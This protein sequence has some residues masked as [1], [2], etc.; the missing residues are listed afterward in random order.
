MKV[1]WE[2][3]MVL[4]V[5]RNDECPCG[6]MQKFKYCC[7][8]KTGRPMMFGRPKGLKKPLTLFQRI[9]VAQR[10][11]TKGKLPPAPE[12]IQKYKMGKKPDGGSMDREIAKIVEEIDNG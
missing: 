7:I 1:V 12:V 6:S 4:N 2:K 9:L 11:K 5:G 3:R 10:N 8:E